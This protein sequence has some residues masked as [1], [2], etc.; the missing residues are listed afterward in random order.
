MSAYTG[1]HVSACPGYHGSR[2]PSTTAYDSV[3][4]AT[5]AKRSA[6]QQIARYR[7]AVKTESR[8]V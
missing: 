5:T 4:P 8:Y 1:Y 2:M 6:P 7:G 3:V